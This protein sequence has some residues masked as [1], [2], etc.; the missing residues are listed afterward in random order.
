MRKGCGKK[1]VLENVASVPVTGIKKGSV[2]FSL[3]AVG[4]VSH[5][6]F[7]NEQKFTISRL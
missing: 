3:K 1:T 4:K 5:E 6:G 2:T 7:R